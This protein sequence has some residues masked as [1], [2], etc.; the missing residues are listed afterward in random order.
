M[1]FINYVKPIIKENQR[2]YDFLRKV[3]E[4]LPDKKYLYENRI[5]ILGGKAVCLDL[6]EAG[7]TIISGG[8]GN[9]VEFEKLCIYKKNVKVIGFDPTDTAELF[10]TKCNYSKKFHQNYEFNKLAITAD[11]QPIKLYYA[12]DDFMSSASSDHKNVL[13]TNYKV[14]ESV[15]LDDIIIKNTNISYLKLDIEGP[16]YEIINNLDA[17]NIP[18]ISIEFHH[19]CDKSFTLEDT[20]SCVRKLVDMGYEVFDYGEFHGRKRKL[21]KYVSKWSDLNCEFLFIKSK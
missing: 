1:S 11:G 14:C 10:I 18:Q 12:D 9:D 3:R 7:S 20:I 5:E 8:I 4:V 16:E 19:H 2:L 6:I 17:I 15:S 21:P 13:G